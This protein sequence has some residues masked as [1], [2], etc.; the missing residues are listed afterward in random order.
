[1]LCE[2]F[3]YA[4]ESPENAGLIGDNGRDLEYLYFFI[5]ANIPS[6]Y[7]IIKVTV[8]DLASKFSFYLRQSF[9]S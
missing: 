4:N 9:A 6:D 2:C 7:G 3:I 8:R 5:H 1:M